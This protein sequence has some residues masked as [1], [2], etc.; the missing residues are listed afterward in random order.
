[1]V[2]GLTTRGESIDA[3][4]SVILDEKTALRL[5]IEITGREPRDPAKLRNE[6]VALGQQVAPLGGKLVTLSLGP[7]S[8]LPPTD[9]A[10]TKQLA[11]TKAA[12]EAR[13]KQLAAAHAKLAQQQPSP[14]AA[15]RPEVKP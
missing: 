11:A 9:E 3:V 6:L 15:S 4:S 2:A 1:M 5:R 14:A 8:L 13:T 7:E 10:L 12:L